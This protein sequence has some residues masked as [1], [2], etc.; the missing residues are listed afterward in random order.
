[1]I[2]N[3]K[4]FWEFIKGLVKPRDGFMKTALVLGGGGARGLAHLGVLRALEKAD[5]SIDLIVG[6]SFGAIVGGMYAQM[7]K[8]VAVENRLREFVH[9]REYR[10]LGL[11]WIRKPKLETEDYLRQLARNV[12]ERVFLNLI[13]HRI[14]VLKAERLENAICFLIDEGTFQQTRIPF[15]CNATD[16]VTGQPVLLTE[17]SLRRAIQASASI[18][19]YFPPVVMNGKKLVDGAVTYNLPVHFARSLGANRVIAVDVHPQLYTENNFRNIFD[20][21]MRANTITGYMLNEQSSQEGIDLVIRPMVSHFYWYEF[22]RAE[23]IIEAGEQ[24]ANQLMET[25]RQM[26][27]PVNRR[28]LF[29]NWWVRKKLGQPSERTG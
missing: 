19:G 3:S 14:S 10:A 25:V 18:P 1:M 21:L 22:D 17:G 5:I 15:A 9:S 28:K 8:A 20:V 16:L 26:L 4:D 27:R 24:A 12:R 29:R 2:D 6:C 13:A 23:E 11:D 7:G